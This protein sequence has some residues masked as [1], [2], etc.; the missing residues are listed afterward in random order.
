[1]AGCGEHT[2]DCGTGLRKGSVIHALHH[3]THTSWLVGDQNLHLGNGEK[4]ARLLHIRITIIGVKSC[5][6]VVSN[7]NSVSVRNVT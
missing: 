1:M 2:F 5:P 4:S 6:D 3:T 7:V